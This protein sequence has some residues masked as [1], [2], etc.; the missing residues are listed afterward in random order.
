MLWPTSGVVVDSQCN[1]AMQFL[2]WIVRRIFDEEMTRVN[3]K[4]SV[5]PVKRET[6]N[7][8]IYE[9]VEAGADKKDIALFRTTD[10]PRQLKTEPSHKY[11][12]VSLRL[13]RRFR[14]E[15]EDTTDAIS[16][17]K[18]RQIVSDYEFDVAYGASAMLGSVLGSVR[19]QAC[20][21]W[22]PVAAKTQA[23]KC[24]RAGATDPVNFQ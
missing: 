24:H 3:E 7:S 13:L 21:W 16:D 12:N 17:T 6:E 22:R 11:I 19:P 2:R 10:E 5:G 4:R 20:D 14:L 8:G 23:G 1:I 15:L 9:G 18:Q